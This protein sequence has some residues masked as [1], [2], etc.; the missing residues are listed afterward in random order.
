MQGKFLE[1]YC[2]GRTSEEIVIDQSAW[3]DLER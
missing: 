3:L 1:G 2:V